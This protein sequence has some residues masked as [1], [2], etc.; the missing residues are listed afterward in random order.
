MQQKNKAFFRLNC[1][2][3]FII[4]DCFQSFSEETLIFDKICEKPVNYFPSPHLTIHQYTMLPMPM[5]P[6]KL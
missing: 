6:A 5:S 1:E 3:K 4:Q 2:Q